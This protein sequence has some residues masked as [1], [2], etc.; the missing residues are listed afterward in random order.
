MVVAA[1]AWAVGALAAAALAWAAGALGAVEFEWQPRGSVVVP[2]VLGAL[3][4]GEVPEFIAGSV[5]GFARRQFAAA[6]WVVHDGQAASVPA[7][8]MA[9]V[10]T[11]IAGTAIDGED[12]AG[13]SQSQQQLSASVTMVDIPM[14]NASPGTA[15][16]G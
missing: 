8:G 4:S 16:S 14:T 2:L 5:P 6:M 7:D 12:G 1:L 3:V 15:T 10:G 9:I 13:G 11:E